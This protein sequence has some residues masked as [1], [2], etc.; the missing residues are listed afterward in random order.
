V[1]DPVGDPGT[2]IWEFAYQRNLF[3][4]GTQVKKKLGKT[5]GKDGSRGVAEALDALVEPPATRRP[6]S[7]RTW[8][9]GSP[10]DSRVRRVTGGGD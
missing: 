2:G 6:A 4:N 7:T 1:G 8:R 10:W 3:A 5:G 9:K